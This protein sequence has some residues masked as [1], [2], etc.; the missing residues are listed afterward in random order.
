MALHRLTP[1][2]AILWALL[3]VLI[4][5]ADRDDETVAQ[6]AT[7]FAIQRA[8]HR[9]EPFAEGVIDT[10]AD[11]YG[12]SLTPDGLTLYFTRRNNRR[13]DEHILVS[14][15]VA[16]EWTTP[17]VAPFSG[18]YYDKEPFVTPD[19]SR[20][21]FASTRPDAPGGPD[22]AFDIWVLERN[23][24]GWSE[25][26]RLGPA[27]NS[28]DYDNYPTVA[29]NGNLYF[30][31]RR[32]G[33]HGDLDIYRAR[34][35]DSAYLPAEN[36]GP[37]INTEATDADPYIAPDESYLIFTS[38]R[39]GTLGAGDLYVSFNRSGAW[40]EPV[41]LGPAIN[42]SEFDYAPLVTPDGKR[43]LFSRGWGGI[44][45]IDIRA[46]GIEP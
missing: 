1:L 4:L 18:R 3:A 22:S 6:A 38:T 27:V 16:G 36:L 29:A 10:E 17:E 8:A 5:R 34:F 44:Y 45:Y 14:R 41:N 33:G 37:A 21:F 26:T 11:E 40:T 2:L 15:K 46:V 20:L 23:G 42:S 19:G 7:P 30:G 28:D 24:S 39:E 25:P 31:S 12:P 32:Q 9:P 43:F 13:G 35:A